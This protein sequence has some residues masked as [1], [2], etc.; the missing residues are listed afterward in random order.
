MGDTPRDELRVDWR[1]WCC[2]E[3]LNI[4]GTI[5]QLLVGATG[6]P[7]ATHRPK[8]QVTSIKSNVK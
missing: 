2:A 4:S 6:S 5:K 3:G 7:A 8:I 1:V